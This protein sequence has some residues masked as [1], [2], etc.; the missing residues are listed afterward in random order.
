[1][2]AHKRDGYDSVNKRQKRA[3]EPRRE[4]R[5]HRISG[6]DT[7]GEAHAGAH[8]HHSLDAEIRVTRLLV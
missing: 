4:N 3:R 8:K 1:M 7:S 6:L 5:E 2:I